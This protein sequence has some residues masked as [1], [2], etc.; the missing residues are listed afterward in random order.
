MVS[1]LY[2]FAPIVVVLHS[3]LIKY[4]RRRLR[5]Q[6]CVEHIVWWRINTLAKRTRNS[7]SSSSYSMNTKI[8][9]Q[10]HSRICLD[11]NPFFAVLYNIQ[12]THV[13]LPDISNAHVPPV[14]RAVHLSKKFRRDH[15]LHSV[16]SFSLSGTPAVLL[17]RRM[18]KVQHASQLVNKSIT[19]EDKSR[20][21]I[22]Y[23]AYFYDLAGNK[24]SLTRL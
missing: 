13:S 3:Y 11:A 2:Q 18:T 15:V 5:K 9:Q 14:C 20:A 7:S 6:T 12:W 19:V 24:N 10:H 17:C 22:R 23:I 21:D 16:R 4:G 8:I 1:G